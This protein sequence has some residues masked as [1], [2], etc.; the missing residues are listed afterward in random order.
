MSILHVTLFGGVTQ[1][2]ASHDN[3]RTSLPPRSIHLFGRI[4]QLPQDRKGAV[5][6]TCT[7]RPMFDL[8]ICDCQ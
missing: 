8:S 5:I 1:L 2:S 6:I 4:S 3:K 7:H